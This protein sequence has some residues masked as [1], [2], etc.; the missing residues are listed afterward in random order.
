M[1]CFEQ[2]PERLAWAAEVIGVRGF[3]D[4]ARMISV[5]ADDGRL[6]GVVVY[7][8]WGACDVSMHVASDGSARWMTR[9]ALVHFFAFPFIQCKLRRVTALVPSKN[10][11]ALKFDRK[12]GFV[13]EGY[14]PHALPDDDLVALGMLR[15][16]CR[17][18]PKKYRH[19]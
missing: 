2:V 13:D 8:T 11:R 15:E 3:R 10:A 16:H 18:I 17:F 5:L 1:I 12:L 7:D 6:R 19:A 9:E 14:F 4:D